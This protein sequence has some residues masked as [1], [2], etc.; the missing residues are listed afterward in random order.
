M[1]P[2]SFSLHSLMG[3]HGPTYFAFPLYVSVCRPLFRGEKGCT[4]SVTNTLWAAA[5]Q[6]KQRHAEMWHLCRFARSPLTEAPV[7][8]LNQQVNACH[9][10]CFSQISFKLKMTSGP[11]Q[12]PA[13]S[14]HDQAITLWRSN[15]H[16]DI[17]FMAKKKRCLHIQSKLGTGVGQYCFYG[18]MRKL[19]YPLVE[20]CTECCLVPSEMLNSS[21]YTFSCLYLSLNML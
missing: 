17:A 13:V 6:A 7:L 16:G 5:E 19:S 2:L 1:L 14:F 20:V 9:I 12:M 3:W 8:P 15:H 4:P 21:Q 10:Y 11:F 18:I